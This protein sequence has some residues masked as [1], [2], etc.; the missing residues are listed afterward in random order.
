MSFVASFELK[1]RTDRQRSVLLLVRGWL[2]ASFRDG[3]IRN[4]FTVW[5]FLTLYGVC[6]ILF[7]MI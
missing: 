2:A 6:L 7:L 1:G 4:A 5:L 3:W